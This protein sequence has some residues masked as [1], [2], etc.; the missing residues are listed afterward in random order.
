M[1]KQLAAVWDIGKTNAKLALA[2]LA[3]GA[4]EATA[5]ASFPSLAGPPYRRL[6]V[7]SLWNWFGAELGRLAA[8]RR[9]E[10]VAVTAHGACGAVVGDEGLAL[11]VYDYEDLAADEAEAEYAKL[12][13]PF[14][15]TFSPPLPGGL[16]YGKSLFWQA[17]SFPE[18]FARA[19][20]ILSYAQYWSWM[21]CG[22]AATE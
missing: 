20:H 12:R 17:R 2:D 4:V 21:L 10:A 14:A 11:P 18:E 13:P 19:R 1:A 16:N 5:T 9:L 15:E 7:D 6:D 3:T 8:G 22:V